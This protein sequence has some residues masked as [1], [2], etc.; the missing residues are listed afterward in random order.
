MTLL[1][2][3]NYFIFFGSIFS[4][5]LLNYSIVFPFSLISLSE[6]ED[7]SLYN[8][9]LTKSIIR[10]LYESNIFINLKIGTPTQK[11]KLQINPNSDDFFVAKIDANFDI[12]YPKRNESYFYYNQ[13]LSSTFSYQVGKESETYFSH[14]HISHYVQD[15]IDFISTNNNKEINIKD[16]KFL[17]AD[18]V[19]E[20]FQGV[21]GLKGFSSIPR[22]KDFFTSLKDYNLTNNYIW[23]LKFNNSK[24]GDLIIGNYPH[25]DKFNNKNCNNDCLFKKKHFVK[26]YS[27][28]SE[29]SWKSQWGL[30]FKKIFIQN[31][32]NLEEILSDCEKCKLVEFNPNLGIIKGSQ[33]YK[34]IINELLF[35]NYINKNICF[36]DIITINKNYEEN[37]YYYYYC[38]ISIKNELK[39]KINSIIFE[40]SVFNTN[41]SLDFNDLFIEKG[42]Y[43]FFKIIF[44]DYYNWI[45]GS[46]F[47]KKYMLIFNAESK[48][49]GF[50]SENIN[51]VDKE[52]NDDQNNDKNDLLIKIIVIIVLSIILIIIGVLIGKKLFGLKRKARLNELEDDF[53]I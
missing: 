41:F 43:I 19:R 51:N 50:Y 32:D 39:N 48:E 47:M 45:F 46:P 12:Y 38:N 23:F 18:Q 28:I 30:N 16:F 3:I 52:N 7:I 2:I 33:K 34:N 22:R 6:I 26:I 37:E 15:N 35:N 29:K 31:K 27:N 40:H 10:D 24:S 49:I 5:D 21:I 53:E 4:D 11:I 42:N 13:S 14:P 36:S 17:L 25:N 44:D 9:S 1:T 20:S 8:E